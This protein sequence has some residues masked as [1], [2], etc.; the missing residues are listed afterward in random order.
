M[1]GIE[2]NWQQPFSFLEHPFDSFGVTANMTMV[3]SHMA[4]LIGT[5]YAYHP[6][7]NQSRFSYNTTLYYDDTVFQARVSVAYRSHYFTAL[8]G[9]YS[10]FEAGEATFNVDASASY[11][12][13]ENFMLTFDALNLT[14]QFQRQYTGYFNDS[15]KYMYVNH[16]TGSDYYMGVK[17]DY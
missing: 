17:Y 2:I 6:L 13:D 7:T 12:F 1:R 8:P 15:N 14:N 11:K 9:S 4:Y 5:A 3:E 10:D 16:Q